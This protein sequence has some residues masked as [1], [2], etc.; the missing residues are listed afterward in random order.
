MELFGVS[1]FHTYTPLRVAD[2]L[3]FSTPSRITQRIAD[4][5]KI[6]VNIGIIYATIGEHEAAVENFNAATSLDQYHAVAYFQ[7][8][9]SNFLL[10]RF[11]LAYTDFEEAF[12][13]L[14]GNQSV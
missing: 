7:C 1:P 10:G 3:L 9:V 14:R 2:R 8:G 12:L 6:L 11:E 4:S 13:Y 5:S